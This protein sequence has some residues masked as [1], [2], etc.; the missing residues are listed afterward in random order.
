MRRRLGPA[1]APPG[2]PTSA[3][4]QTL[5]L[6]VSATYIVS[7]SGNTLGVAVPVVVRHFHAS[8]FAATLV[9]LTPSLTSTA[10]MLGLG[11]VGDLLG[12]RACYLAGLS[13]FTLASLLLGAAPDVWVVVALQVL[14]ACG[15]ATVWANSAAILLEE[16]P[17]DRFQRGLGLYIAAIAVAELMGPTLGGIV[18]ETI[19]WR[20]ISG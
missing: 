11:R 18:A 16:L 14:Q 10:V 5:W 4:E 17:P 8:A 19:G 7:L 6:V 2:G 3:A 20:W 15:V 13:I 1:P 9:V 12:R